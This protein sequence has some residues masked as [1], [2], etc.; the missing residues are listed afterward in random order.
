MKDTQNQSEAKVANLTKQLEQQAERF[1]LMM[2]DQNKQHLTV[3]RSEKH[4]RS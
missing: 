1:M 4:V 2:E 3:K